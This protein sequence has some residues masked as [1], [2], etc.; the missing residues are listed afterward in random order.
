MINGLFEV[1]NRPSV[2]SLFINLMLMYFFKLSE[3]VHNYDNKD[4]Q[5]VV[6]NGTIQEVEPSIQDAADCDLKS[7]IEWFV[8][9]EYIGNILE[10]GHICSPLL[11]F[12]NLMFLIFVKFYIL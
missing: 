1:F 12:Q 5:E 4:W 7:F 8:N 2:Y 10:D 3:L 9:R 6:V 11:T